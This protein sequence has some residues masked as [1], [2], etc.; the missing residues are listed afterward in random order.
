S[1]RMGI[2]DVVHHPSTPTLLAQSRGLRSRPVPTRSGAGAAALRLFPVRG[3]PAPVHR[4]LLRNDGG[5]AR[6]R[7]DPPAREAIG[8]AVATGSTRPARDAASKIWNGHGSGA[9][10]SD[11]RSG[12]RRA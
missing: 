8:C 11:L 6:T 7:D 4:R 12:A 10:L 3:G 2:S 1:G 5:S 9:C